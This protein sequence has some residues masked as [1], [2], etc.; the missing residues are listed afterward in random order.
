LII[1]VTP[2]LVGTEDTHHV[3]MSDEMKDLYNAGQRE[4][5]YNTTDVDLN[6][7]PP[8]F[9]PDEKKSKKD[10]KSKKNKKADDVVISD[11][12]TENTDA[13]AEAETNTNDENVE[14][15]GDNY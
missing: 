12:P 15:F 11:Y 2:R 13:N 8:P 6:E 14:V 3:R 5:N 4:Y 10:K 9:D 7:L 1:V